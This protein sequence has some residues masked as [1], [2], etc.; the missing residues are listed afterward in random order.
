MNSRVAIA[1]GIAGVVLA[2]AVGAAYV[3][4]RGASRSG[5]PCRVVADGKSYALDRSQATNAGIIA[6]AAGTVGLPH[7]AVTIGI[8]AA[9]QESQLHNLG[10]GD[11]DSL[12][13]FQQRPSQ[14][15][16][17]RAQI[18]DPYFAA[19]SFF[20]HLA[21]LDGWQAMTVSDAAQQVQ[22]SARPNAYAT[23]EHEA[24]AL[25]RAT[26][27]ELPGALSCSN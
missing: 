24:R 18:L 1:I 3:A 4:F 20:R 23:W 14:G 9:L 8:A 26:T 12:G 5:L 7:H 16:G 6:A 22:H 11:R 10:Y 19:T 21:K 2:G 13:L 25:A 27:G 17:T 15:W